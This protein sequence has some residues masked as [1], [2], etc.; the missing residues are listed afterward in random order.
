MDAAPPRHMANPTIDWNIPDYWGR[1]A[2]PDSEAEGA[3]RDCF[4]LIIYSL[5]LA[6][7]VDPD[8]RC[9]VEASI[10]GAQP[11]GFSTGL[12]AFLREAAP[13]GSRVDP[14]RPEH[15][16]RHLLEA[17]DLLHEAE[18]ATAMMIADRLASWEGTMGGGAHAAGMRAY[19]LLAE[20]CISEAGQAAV[21]DAEIDE[22]PSP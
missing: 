4:D 11:E 19:R 8:E 13:S 18:P 22:S 20:A 6:G 7:K 10:V 12:R 15:A 17:V 14:V 2:S 3:A 1:P 5:T 21:D 16:A 9:I